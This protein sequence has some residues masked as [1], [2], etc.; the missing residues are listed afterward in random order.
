METAAAAV[1]IHKTTLYE[2]LR[3]G[4][5]IQIAHDKVLAS[6]E[7][8]AISED[9]MVLLEFPYAVEK[10]MAESEL[11]D[12]RQINAAAKSGQWQAAAWR[13]ERKFPQKWGRKIQA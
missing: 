13:L 1:G 2:W 3:K 6:G 5:T 4:A 9:D 7:P 10:A 8:F 12:L 11:S